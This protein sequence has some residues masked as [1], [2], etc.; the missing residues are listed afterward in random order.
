[1][2]IQTFKDAKSYYQIMHPFLIENEAENN[3]A[4]GLLNQIIDGKYQNPFLAVAL[5]E[6]EVI[7]GFLMTPP[8]NLIIFVRPEYRQNH[9]EIAEKLFQ[10]LMENK[11]IVPGLIGEKKTVKDFTIIWKQMTGKKSYTAM[12]QRIYR[13]DKV[14]NVRISE[15]SMRKATVHDF[16]LI[17]KWIIGFIK[18]TG[19]STLTPEQ[20]RK[21]AEEMIEKEKSVYLWDVNGK[22]VSMARS[23]RKTKNGIT[24]NLV[25]TP[26]EFRKEGYG[27]SVVATL[28][29]KL[30]ETYDFC[31][32][33]T[34]L[35]YP[36]SNKIYMEIGYVPVCDSTLMKFECDW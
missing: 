36:T 33:Y 22:P 31:T 30:L 29:R 14:N 16:E 3:L 28:S 23:A 25:Y 8:H 20:A 5:S 21:R 35:D 4:L 32:L 9:R 17:S 1:M 2:K 18:D 13:L 27:T 24:I 7:A 26:N 10:F 19:E 34:D 6:E 11:I 12:R 15:G